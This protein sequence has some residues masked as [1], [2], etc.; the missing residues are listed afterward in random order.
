LEAAALSTGRGFRSARFV[1]GYTVLR[2]A[3][4]PV[5]M[6][7]LTLD[8]RSSGLLSVAALALF[9]AAAATDWLD[10]LLA[11][12]WQVT[13]TLGSF[14]DTTA[15]KLLVTGVLFA[16]VAIE[17]TSQWIAVLI[18]ARELVILG[19]R[20]VVA[21]QGTVMAPSRLGKLKTG[22]QFL[23]LS[24][25]IVRPDLQ[26]GGQFID[27]WAMLAAAGITVI[28][29]IDYLTKFSSSLSERPQ[30]S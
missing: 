29:A 11:R 8:G 13:T 15:D 3:L 4:T 24:L 26:I 9:L 6:L 1:A 28:S 14:L 23:A 12:R 30:P 20:G 17:R 22:I 5:V 2:I 21:S 27:E 19:L 18:V 25:A 10:G 16:L 7:L